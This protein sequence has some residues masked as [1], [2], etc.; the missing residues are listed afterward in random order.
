[1][2]RRTIGRGTGAGRSAYSAVEVILEGRTPERSPRTSSRRQNSVRPQ[3]A[4]AKARSPQVLLAYQMNGIDLPRLTGF[5]CG[6][7]SRMVWSCIHQ[8][9]A[10]N[11]CESS[12]F[13]RIFPVD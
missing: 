12:A 13:Q 5:R 11:D 6:H 1:M 7:C 8:V 10:E 9:V 3:S 2:D 4:L